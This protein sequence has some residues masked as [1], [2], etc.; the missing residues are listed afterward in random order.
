MIN[1]GADQTARS[2]QAGL[3]ICCSHATMSGFLASRHIVLVIFTCFFIFDSILDTTHLCKTDF[4]S[5]LNILGL[6][7]GLY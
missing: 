1:I 6:D 5:C 7:L 2:A 3:R 4:F